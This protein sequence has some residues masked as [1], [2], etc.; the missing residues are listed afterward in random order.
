MNHNIGSTSC[1]RSAERTILVRTLLCSSAARYC[2]VSRSRTIPDFAD[3]GGTMPSKRFDRRKFIAAG[4][5]TTAVS[6]LELAGAL[7]TAPARADAATLAPSD[8]Q[9]AVG[10]FIQ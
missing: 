4:T 9:F 7:T 10:D 8:I 5:V 3:P 6:A 2:A 1:Y